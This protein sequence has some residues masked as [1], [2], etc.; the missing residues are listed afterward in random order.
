MRLLRWLVLCLTLLCLVGSSWAQRLRLDNLQAV[1]KKITVKWDSSSQPPFSPPSQDPANSNSPAYVDVA[2]VWNNLWRTPGSTV[3]PAPLPFS[4]TSATSFDD[5]D[6]QPNIAYDYYL[7]GYRARYARTYQPPT[8]GQPGYWYWAGPSQAAWQSNTIHVMVK[9]VAATSAAT[10]DSRLDMRFSTATLLDYTFNAVPASTSTPAAPTYYRGGL[11]AG[12]QQDSS[13]VGRSY[14]RFA[15]IATPDPSLLLWP[16]GGL[17]VFVPRLARTGSAALTTRKLIDDTLSPTSLVWSNAPAMG[18]SVARS[19]TISWNSATPTKQWVS[20]NVSPDIQ[21]A[22]NT[23]GTMALALMS[24]NETATGWVY[25]A[26]PGYTDPGYSLPA[27]SLTPPNGL[28]PFLLFATLGPGADLATISVDPTTVT[29]GNTTAV[30]G[31]V[32]LQSIAPTGGMEVSLAS[33]NSAASVPNSVII[34]A[35]QNSASF[36]VTWSSVTT[37]TTATITGIMGN[38]KTA[39]LTINPG[40]GGGG[41]G[42]TGTLSTLVINP[43]NVAV[44]TSATGTVT[45]TSAAPTGGVEVLLMSNNTSA[46]Q[47]P[48]SVTVPAGQTSQTFTITTGPGYA[49]YAPVTIAASS[50]SSTKTASLI[51]HP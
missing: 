34:P 45:L 1:P 44:G 26:R 18:N 9:A 37:A 12:Y 35:G 32:T 24:N 43:S 6:W 22:I 48:T 3:T 15:N 20:I 25:V 51:V 2:I 42:G 23:D 47:V 17:Q 19:G 29:S 40:S 27:N 33:N 5:T 13:K 10:A 39:T 14:L 16:V 30:S 7:T 4:F 31:T 36:D 50:G 8:Q 46:A 41:G 49:Y 11:F 38:I 21:E 28:A